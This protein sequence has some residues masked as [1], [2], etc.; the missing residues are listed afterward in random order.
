MQQ[1]VWLRTLQNIFLS[2]WN[3]R[4]KTLCLFLLAAKLN[5]VLRCLFLSLVQIGTSQYIQMLMFTTDLCSSWVKF[6]PLAMFVLMSSMTGCGDSRVLPSASQLCL[7]CGILSAALSQASREAARRLASDYDCYCNDSTGKK[8]LSFLSF[9]YS[10]FF[11][12]DFTKQHQK[13]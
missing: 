7:H 4:N 1:H 12:E 2:F 10:S 3:Q 13:Y 5:Y 11:I 6:L 8:S 9:E